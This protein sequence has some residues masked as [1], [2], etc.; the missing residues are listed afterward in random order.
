MRIMPR[1]AQNRQPPHHLWPPHH[2]HHHTAV[3]DA[4]NPVLKKS[5]P[6]IFYIDR[7]VD[8]LHT[9]KWGCLEC[10]KPMAQISPAPPDDT[11][12]FCSEECQIL[13]LLKET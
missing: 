4:Y 10:R 7:S 1:Q 5:F 3:I 2:Y 13:N 12:W 9:W 11:T 8:F 6:R